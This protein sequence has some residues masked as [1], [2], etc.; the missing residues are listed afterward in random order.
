MRSA[1]LALSLLLA[2][3]TANAK[4]LPAADAAAIKA[5]GIPIYEQ[6]VFLDGGREVGYRFATSQPPAAVKQ[7][8]RAKLAD[9]VLFD[10]YGAWVL[11]KERKGAPLPEIIGKRQVSVA[12]NPDMVGMYKIN[13]DM[14]TEIVIV[15]P[16]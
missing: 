7:W 5:A 6:A 3:S 11:H 2:V 10:Q 12:T 14:T 16:K 8:Y 13:K 15:A 9:W 4:D 1:L